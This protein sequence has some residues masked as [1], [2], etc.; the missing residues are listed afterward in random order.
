MRKKNNLGICLDEE[1][2]PFFLS[3]KIPS[4]ANQNLASMAALGGDT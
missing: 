1:F 3:F 2:I 4:M